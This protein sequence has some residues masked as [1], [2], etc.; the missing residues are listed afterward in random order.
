MFNAIVISKEKEQ[1]TTLTSIDKSMLNDGD[2]T[3]N[4]AY[5]TLNYKDALAI[6][7]KPGVVR[8]WPMIPGIDLA[9]TVTESSSNLFE[10]GDKVL[11]NGYGI[12]EVH[13]GGLAQQARVKSEW[14]VPLPSGISLK[15][16]MAI[17]TAGYTAM[18]S[19]LAL[20]KQD[21]DPSSGEVLVTGAAGGVGSVAIS[22][23]SKLGYNVIAVSGRP[24]QAAYLKAL[25]AVEVLPRSELEGSAKPLA[26]QRYAGV[27]DVA[28]SNILA[29]AI[30]QTQYGGVVTACGLA[31]GMDLPTNVA[32]FILRGI[33]LIGIDSVMAPMQNRLQ[34]WER[35]TQDLDLIML[36]NMTQTVGLNQVLQLAPELLKGQ[37]RGRTVVDVNL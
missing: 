26:K 34:A 24:E 20:E 36:D 9:G 10:I 35:L 1:S 15:Q 6:C 13:S 17:G 23:L 22:L 29:N 25:G 14:L 11:V 27:I 32:P 19:V 5:S 18:L 4:V 37:V 2:V 16:S 3:I 8:E 21:V 31:A 30:A 7:Q 12:G 28:G 33:K